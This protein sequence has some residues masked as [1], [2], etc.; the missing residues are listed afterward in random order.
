MICLYIIPTVTDE[1][2]F[3]FFSF[4]GRNR[5]ALFNLHVFLKRTAVARGFCS[6]PLG[7]SMTL[8]LA[9][10]TAFHQAAIGYSRIILTGDLFKG[11]SR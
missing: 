9:P 6:Q 5:W 8:P 1:E 4:V 3:L 11:A 2:C 7:S 10:V